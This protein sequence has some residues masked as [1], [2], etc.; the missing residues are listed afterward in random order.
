MYRTLKL[1]FIASQTYIKKE[2]KNRKKLWEYI[3][4]IS[5]IIF[6]SL[7]SKKIE[8]TKH[9]KNNPVARIVKNWAASMT[10]IFLYLCL[11][12]YSFHRA[13]LTLP[14]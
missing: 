11:A 1:S 10:I 14:Q 3:L 8:N 2:D 13:L 9:K 6:T 5:L 4:D 12:A 7:T